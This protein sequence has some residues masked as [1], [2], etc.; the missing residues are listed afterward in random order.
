M[1]PGHLDD[2]TQ[3]VW[4]HVMF[5]FCLVMFGINGYRGIIS[6]C[7]TSERLCGLENVARA[8][9]Q[10]EQVPSVV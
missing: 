3:A 10:N 4:R 5:I 9:I 2:T 7:E 1:L 6:I 8:Y